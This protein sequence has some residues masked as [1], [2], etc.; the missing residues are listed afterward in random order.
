MQMQQ[1]KYKLKIN[2]M[3]TMYPIIYKIEKKNKNKI[4]INKLKTEKVSVQLEYTV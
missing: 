3:Y 2:I 1:Q 4:K